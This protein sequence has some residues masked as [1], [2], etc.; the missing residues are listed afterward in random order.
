MNMIIYIY[1]YTRKPPH[2]CRNQNR[3]GDQAGK[4]AGEPLCMRACV[5][6][7]VRAYVGAW[8]LAWAWKITNQFDPMGA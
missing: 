4:C 7:C 8:A 3:F 6:A 2:G 1:I 5:H